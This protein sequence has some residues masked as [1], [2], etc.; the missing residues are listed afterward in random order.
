MSVFSLF[1]LHGTL[2][3]LPYGK[4][5]APHMAWDDFTAKFKAIADKATFLDAESWSFSVHLIKYDERR[6]RR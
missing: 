1:F 2:A 3:F 6:V 5:V 4:F